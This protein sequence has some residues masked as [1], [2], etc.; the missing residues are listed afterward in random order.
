MKLSQSFSAN[1]S[2][3][4]IKALSLVCLGLFFSSVQADVLVPVLR[5]TSF[6]E[7]ITYQRELRQLYPNQDPPTGTSLCGA[8]KSRCIEQEVYWQNGY[9]GTNSPVWSVGTWGW[10]AKCRRPA[11]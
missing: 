8:D 11:L 6:S 9:T 2:N 1:Q 5:D 10:L 7:G 3:C 4:L